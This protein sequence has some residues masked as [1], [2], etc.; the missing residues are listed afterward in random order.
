[1]KNEQIWKKIFKKN[2]QKFKNSKNFCFLFKSDQQRSSRPTYRDM[3][4]QPE[5]S[6]SPPA[7][8]SSRHRNEPDFYRPVN[9][10]YERNNRS[11]VQSSRSIQAN[12]PIK[13]DSSVQADTLDTEPTK[14]IQPRRLIRPMTASEEY[15][16]VPRRSMSLLPRSPSADLGLTQPVFNQ[17]FLPPISAPLYEDELLPP[18]VYYANT[19]LALQPSY[20]APPTTTSL[21][22]YNPYEMPVTSPYSYD[23]AYY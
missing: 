17:H 10:V 11:P 14:P 23:L 4:Q 22:F 7:A 12:I 18:P 15:A 8:G 16:L 13:R 6:L 1:M 5:K 3:G 21:P 20:L 2:S 19:H 9:T